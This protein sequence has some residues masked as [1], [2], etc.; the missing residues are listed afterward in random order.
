MGKTSTVGWQLAPRVAAMAPGVTSSFVREALHRA[1]K[2]AGPLPPA[3]DAAD[4][5]LAEQH[6]DVDKAIHEVIENHVRYAGAQQ[7]ADERAA[8]RLRRVAV[9]SLCPQFSQTLSQPAAACQPEARAS[10]SV[11]LLA[12][13]VTSPEYLL[14]FTVVCI[15]CMKLQQT[16]SGDQQWT[17][18]NG[19]PAALPACMPS[20]PGW[21]ANNATKSPATFCRNGAGSNASPRPRWSNG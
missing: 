4:K 18:W 17:T 20:G 10:P 21:R 15:Y 7:T 14:I 1:I 8:L 12:L 16:T 19:S 5:Q 13:S 11:A 3:A 9:G 2:G 6:G